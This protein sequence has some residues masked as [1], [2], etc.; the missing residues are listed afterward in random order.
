MKAK[1]FIE[2]LSRLG[3]EKTLVIEDNQGNYY[4][5]FP[6]DIEDGEEVIRVVVDLEPAE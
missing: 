3:E 1:D 4:D 6:H 5:I 2:L